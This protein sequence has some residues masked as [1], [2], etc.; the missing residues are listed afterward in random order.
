[1]TEIKAHSSSSEYMR[2]KK[3]LKQSYMVDF[4]LG[5]DHERRCFLLSSQGFSKEMYFVFG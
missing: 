2:D 4:A 5:R 1:M 3:E